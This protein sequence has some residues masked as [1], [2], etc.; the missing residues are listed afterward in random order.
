MDEA[1]DHASCSEGEDT[2]KTSVYRVHYSQLCR[3]NHNIGEETVLD[4][5]DLTHIN[6]Y[7]QTVTL[8]PQM[9]LMLTGPK[10]KVVSLSLMRDFAVTLRTKMNQARMQHGNVYLNS[11]LYVIG[12]YHETYLS[13]CERYDFIT[14]VWE[15]LPSLNLACSNGTSVSLE[16]SNSIYVLGGMSNWDLSRPTIHYK[17]NFNMRLLDEIQALYIGNLQWCTLHMKLPYPEHSIVSWKQDDSIYFIVSPCFVS[18]YKLNS[19]GIAYVG[20]TPHVS[21]RV[22]GEGVFHK[23]T[24]HYFNV[25]DD[26]ESWKFDMSSLAM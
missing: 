12:G 9:E 25:D 10:Q 22:Q 13:H 3:L 20:Y 17:D 26:Y 18:I 11:Y 8:I 23:G 16:S 1:I 21:Y 4:L 5:S 6:E 2:P 24:L 14:Q 15:V 19:A 7:K